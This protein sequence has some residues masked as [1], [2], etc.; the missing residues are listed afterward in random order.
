MLENSLW[1]HGESKEPRRRFLEESWWEMTVTPRVV[2]V[3][4]WEGWIWG[5][6]ERWSW[7]DLLR[8]WMWGVRVKEKPKLFGGSLWRA[9]TA[10][11]GARTASGRAG[12]RAG[13]DGGQVGVW[14]LS[15]K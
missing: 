9:G 12:G 4:G 10:I 5:E 8:D 3:L 2:E 7:Q 11:R 14:V 1:G 15:L 6:S 13:V